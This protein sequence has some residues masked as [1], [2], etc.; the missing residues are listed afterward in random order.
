LT[1]PSSVKNG[2]PIWPFLLL[3][4]YLTFASGWLFIRL[5]FSV[6]NRRTQTLM[7]V[8][9]IQLFGVLFAAGL[10][11]VSILGNRPLLLV[12]SVGVAVAMIGVPPDFAPE[13]QL[14]DWDS[15]N[16]SLQTNKH[17]GQ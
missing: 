12:E 7:P 11:S 10:I 5:I 9:F 16:N 3:F 15:R 1:I 4:G 2:V 13:N 17:T 14:R 6:Q 8:W